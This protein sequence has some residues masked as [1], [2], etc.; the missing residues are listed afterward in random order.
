MIL[1]RATQTIR[2]IVKFVV[3][4]ISFTVFASSVSAPAFCQLSPNSLWSGQAQCQLNVQSEGYI[5]QEIQTWTITGTPNQQSGRQVYPATW[6]VSS[7]G[8]AQ[9]QLQGPQVLAAQWSGRVPGMNAPIAIFVRA[10]DG[11]LL[12]GA[13]HAQLAA[14]NATIASKQVGGSQASSTTDWVYEWKFPAIEDAATSTNV[15]GTET[16][17]VSGNAIAIPAANASGTA[18]RQWQFIK[19]AS[20]IAPGTPSAA[21]MDTPLVTATRSNSSIPTSTIAP[22]PTPPEGVASIT[23][24]TNSSNS[25][26]AG[27]IAPTDASRLAATNAAANHQ[28]ASALKAPPPPTGFKATAWDLG[29]VHFEWQP[30]TGAA[31]YRLEGPGL[32]A[33]GVYISAP[34]TNVTANNIPPGSD[35]WKLASVNGS[36]IWDQSNQAE[37]SAMVR[38]PPAHSPPWLSKANGAGKPGSTLA[39]Y[40]SLCSQCIPGTNF[41]DVMQALG[42]PF[43]LV[44]DD[45]CFQGSAWDSDCGDAWMPPRADGQ[46]ATYINV[47]EFEN[48]TRVTG[49]WNIGAPNGR[50][51][52]FTKTSDHGLQVI[53]KQTD[54]SWFLSFTSA[55]SNL[56]PFDWATYDANQ[57]APMSFEQRVASAYK[58][59]G[60]VTFDS[61]GTKYPPHACLA[62]HGGQF[63]GSGVIGATLLPI[64]PGLLKPTSFQIG[65]YPFQTTLGFDANN[66]RKLNQAVIGSAPSPAVVRYLTGLY[67]MDPRIANGTGDPNYVPQGWK[68][69]ANTYNTGIKPYCVMC[70]LATPSNLDFTVPNNFFQNKNLIYTAI[71]SA[72]SMPHAEAPYKAFWTKDTGPFFLQGWLVEQLGYQSCP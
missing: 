9:R 49:C 35:L 45:P 48:S 56:L 26:Q 38:Y 32:D 13:W 55:D 22:A 66:V 72:H 71:C 15:S 21:I 2:S 69:Q 40:I 34:A 19:G 6:S 67:G 23:S 30:V 14:P 46:A 31:K 57:L 24:Q 37:A 16:V 59:T 1:Y 3:M 53:V 5:H 7:Q 63:T 33:T 17:M 27:L 36:G 43:N 20:A 52:C 65:A 61:E 50:M 25:I 10:S 42:L 68:Q 29:A 41:K 51:V 47:T 44:G 28:V 70:H 4:S 12:I 54:Y 39:H 11:R 62:C 18:S 64:D 8:G 58:L 60:E